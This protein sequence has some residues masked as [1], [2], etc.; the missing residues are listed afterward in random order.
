MNLPLKHMT[1]E[2]FAAWAEAQELGRYEL[3]DGV[4]VK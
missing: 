1:A 2:E 4:V 3:I